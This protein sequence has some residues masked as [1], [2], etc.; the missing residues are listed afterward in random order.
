MEFSLNYIL[1]PLIAFYAIIPLILDGLERKLKA[2]LQSRIGPPITQT[3]YDVLKLLLVKETKNQPTLPYVTLTLLSSMVMGLLALHYVTLYIVQGD[4]I[5][6]FY[7]LALLAVFTST[8]TVTPLLVPNPYSYIGGMREV[9]LAVVNEAAFI[10]SISLYTIILQ[11]TL[12]ERVTWVSIL[13]MLLVAIVAFISSYATSS[14]VPFDIAEAEPELASGVFIE[15]SGRILALN[16]YN[17]LLRR[18][19]AKFLVLAPTVILI[20]GHGLIS[21]ILV[22][23]LTPLIWALYTTIAV[24]LGRS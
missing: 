5:N 23:L 3:V 16:I 4:I 17:L 11:K 18:L 20:S 19:A 24:V 8:H 12:V 22:L 1:I 15:F 21:L 9:M 13:I 6:M 2:A 7:A 10:T 14:R